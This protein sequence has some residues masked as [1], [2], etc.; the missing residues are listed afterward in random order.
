[1]STPRR[2][3]FIACSRVSLVIKQSDQVVVAFGRK[4]R[5]H[6]SPHRLLKLHVWHRMSKPVLI[7]QAL[8]YPSSC[9]VDCHCDKFRSF[10]L[11]RTW[12]H[13]SNSSRFRKRFEIGKVRSFF[14]LG[15]LF[16]QNR[17][18]ITDGPEICI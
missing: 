13:Y 3:T 12:L 10:L 8:L 7:K 4:P 11:M 1:M 15:H 9:T 17:S 14:G 2:A 18:Q 6:S 16:P 5:I